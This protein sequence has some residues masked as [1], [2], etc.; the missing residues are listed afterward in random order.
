[1][2]LVSFEEC[3]PYLSGLNNHSPIFIFRE[4]DIINSVYYGVLLF[5]FF[6]RQGV[7]Y[8]LLGRGGIF[9]SREVDI[10]V[11]T[12]GVLLFFIFFPGKE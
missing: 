1:M 6:P 5:F 9:I 3:G 12:M 4:V 2:L 7:M 11:Y 8:L 10:I